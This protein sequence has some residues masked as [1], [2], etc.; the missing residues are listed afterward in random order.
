MS[1]C[2]SIEIEISRSEELTGGVVCRSNEKKKGCEYTLKKFFKEDYIVTETE[3]FDPTEHY[4]I[5]SFYSNWR[6][7]FWL[8]KHQTML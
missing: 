2:N 4:R 5:R 6:Y 1:R 3:F 8:D 7:D